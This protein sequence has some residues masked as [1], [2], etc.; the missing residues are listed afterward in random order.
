MYKLNRFEFQQNGLII[1]FFFIV[2]NIKKNGVYT[3]THIY[4]LRFTR[5]TTLH[6]M[7]GARMVGALRHVY[8][9]IINNIMILKLL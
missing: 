7:D 6:R 1:L 9:Y 3:H 8:M 2:R 4:D 5:V